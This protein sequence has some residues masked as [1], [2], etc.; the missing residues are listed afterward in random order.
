MDIAKRL[1]D[2]GWS[3]ALWGATAGDSQF[4]DELLSEHHTTEP[5]RCVLVCAGERG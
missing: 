4:V 5:D 1:V 2:N 3:R